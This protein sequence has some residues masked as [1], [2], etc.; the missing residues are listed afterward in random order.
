[1]KGKVI[2][3]MVN[4]RFAYLDEALQPFVPGKRIEFYP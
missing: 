4:G 2:S 1:M 3:T